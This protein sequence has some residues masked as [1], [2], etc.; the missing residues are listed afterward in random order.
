MTWPEDMPPDTSGTRESQEVVPRNP[1]KPSPSIS[2]VLKVA[3]IALAGTGALL[4][5]S[6]ELVGFVEEQQAVQV[7]FV[8]DTTIPVS[9]PDCSTDIAPIGAGQTAK[10]PVAS[11]HP[12]DCT[13]DNSLHGTIVRCVTMPRNVVAGVVIVIRLSQIHTCR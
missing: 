5:G 8:N 4:F 3:S 12:N 11:D 9:L 1:G 7:T 2:Q 6:L 13:V 10:L